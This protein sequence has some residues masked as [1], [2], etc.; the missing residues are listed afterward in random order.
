MSNKIKK[1][2]FLIII[3]TM[4][5]TNTLGSH[6]SVYAI[7]EWPKIESNI[8]YDKDKTKAEIQ[9][10]V[11][12]T[13]KKVIHEIKNPDGNIMDMGQ[14][15]WS[16]DKNG[17]YTFK[18]TYMDTLSNQK[19]TEDEK[20][21][22]D[23]IGVLEQQTRSFDQL[24]FQLQQQHWDPKADTFVLTPFL[25][26]PSD[27]HGGTISIHLPQ[28]IKVN[29]DDIKTDANIEAV[30]VT[31][32]SDSSSGMDISLKLKDNANGNIG[33]DISISQSDFI[34]KSKV[35]SYTIEAVYQSKDGKRKSNSVTLIP[36][37]NW[38]ENITYSLTKAILPNETNLKFQMTTKANLMQFGDDFVGKIVLP[39]DMVKTL[40]IDENQGTVQADGSLEVRIEKSNIVDSKTIKKD[41]RIS[42]VAEEIVKANI[43][44]VPFLINIEFDDGRTDTFENEVSF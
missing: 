21:V 36:A 1:I 42:P 40:K 11:V 35:S 43:R 29:A 39:S 15:T 37:I 38:S 31:G 10:S 26:M 22:V 44:S 12:N 5:L 32:S 30:Y 3:L 19:N 8:V 27:V 13:E 17:E 24:Q 4:V 20:I 33:K 25:I 7:S 18:V 6:P 14:L 34:A 28:Y 41:I 2:G 16:T 9:L 23:E